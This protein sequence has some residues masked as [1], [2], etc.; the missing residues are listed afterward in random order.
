MNSDS[1]CVIIKT[2]PVTLAPELFSGAR[3]YLDACTIGLPPLTTSAAMVSA[4]GQWTRG[5]AS[6]EEYA[7]VVERC[8]ALYAALVNVPGAE[9]AIGSSV[10]TMVAQIAALVPDG[11]QVLCA[12]G[13]FSSMVYP[14]YALAHRGV[15]VRHAAPADLAESITPDTFLVSFSLI[16][17]ATGEVADAEAITEAARRDGTLTLCDTTQAVGCYPVDGSIFDATVC[18]AYK[19]LCAPRGAAFLT[20]GDRIRSIAHSGWSSTSVPAQAGWYAGNSIWDSCYGPQIDLSADA[21]RF[22][23]SPAWLSWVGTEKSLELFTGFDISEVWQNNIALA[24]TLAENLGLDA[25]DQAIMSW[26]DPDGRHAAR[27][28]RAGISASTRAGRVRVGFHLWNTLRDVELVTDAITDATRGHKNT[29][30]TQS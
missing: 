20:L 6:A 18:H 24:N 5:D 23:T 26:V 28:S 2:H 13:D 19:W 1:Y 27:L 16:Q 30:E 15:T 10:S 25:R 17:S 8:R 9:V 11:A 7:E 4:V 3:G 21:R 29:L 22:D 14:F 12:D